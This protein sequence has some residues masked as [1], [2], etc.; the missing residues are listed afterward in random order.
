[1]P[2]GTLTAT[3]Y[4]ML[5]E[6]A[7]ILVWRAGTDAKC[8][9][10]NERWLA[11]SG[12]TLAQETGDGWAEGVHPEDFDRCVATYLDAFHARRSFEMEYRLKR[13]DGEYRWLFDRGVPYYDERGEFAGYIGSCIDVTDKIEA[14]ERLKELR[15]AELRTL[16]GMLPI[17]AWCKQ[18]KN[19]AGY[20]ES[21]EV[22][23]QNHATVD[24]SHGLC[25]SCAVRLQDDFQDAL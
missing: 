19:D 23:V 24:F 16:R 25:P 1:M 22:Y 14:R 11:F 10:F 3:E 20:W 2:A 8:N 21:V 9:Y 4:A 7:P 15:E 12:R 6:Q 5:V 18:V 17:C 13:H